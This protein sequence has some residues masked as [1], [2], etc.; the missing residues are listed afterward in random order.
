MSKAS[1]AIAA[2]ARSRDLRRAQAAFAGFNLAEHAVWVAML[3][4]AFERGGGVEAGV[5][6]IVQLLPA[7]V[8]APFLGT[9]ADRWSPVRVQ[10]LGY[11]IQAVAYLITGGVM[12]AGGPAVVVYGFGSVAATL[13]TVSRPTQAVLTPLLSRTPTEFTAAMVTAGWVENAS[14]LAAP[15]LA[16]VLLAT[17]STGSVFLAAAT[18][19]AAAAVLLLPLRSAGA[20]RGDRDRGEIAPS[21]LGEVIEGIRALREHREARLLVGFIGLEHVGWGAIDLLAVILALDVLDIGASGAA[22]LGGAFGL[23]AVIG[24]AGAVVLIGGRRLAPAVL[25]GALAWGAVLILLGLHPTVVVAFSLFAVAGGGRAVLDVGARTL[26][27]RTARP[28]VVSRVFGIAEAL[29]MLG[30]AVGSALAPFLDSLGG[31]TAALVG[32]GAFVALLALVRARAVLAV[33]AA[34]Q[35]P[36]VEL[37][38]LRRLPIFG[39]LPAID[40]EGLAVALV[41]EQYPGGAVIIQE[42]APGHRYFAI[43]SGDVDVV[44]GGQVVGSLGRGEGFGEIALLNDTPRNATIRARSDVVVYS[45]EREPFLAA[46]TGHAATRTVADRIAAERRRD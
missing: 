37:A 46:L 7:V 36:V 38:L 24:A 26:L 44:V 1:G 13:A 5:V 8:A 4:F 32:V 41:Q 30:L 11:A 28:A 27:L 2:V 33:D 40:L 15:A 17:G 25:G 3:V 22:Y 20:G 43:A 9:L 29:A 16:G 6:S 10:T 34:A 39:L 18:T 35:V 23:G 19:M 14:V 42:G 31:A 45:L 12:L 21:G